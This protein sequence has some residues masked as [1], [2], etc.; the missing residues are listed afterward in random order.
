MQVINV[1]DINSPVKITWKD[2]NYYIPNDGKPHWIP[3]E[4]SDNF[5]G[6]LRIISKD[7]Q[8]PSYQPP[9]TIIDFWKTK[10]ILDIPFVGPPIPI[11][12][13]IKPITISPIISES[14]LISD[15]QIEEK[16]KELE[17]IKY[18]PKDIPVILEDEL[19]ESNTL[20]DDR[21]EVDIKEL[22]RLEVVNEVQEKLAQGKQNK[23]TNVPILNRR[24]TKQYNT[25][26]IK[27]PSIKP[28]KGKRVSKKCKDKTKKEYIERV[29]KNKKYIDR[30]NDNITARLD[31][32]ENLENNN[33][34]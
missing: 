32:I 19:E 22:N 26:A 7:P 31:M 17:S 18:V 9:T 14:N 2:V 4:V 25:G 3:D 6:L 23:Y 27:D 29:N 24:A 16:L 15:E 33:K 12:P 13:T 34:E 8:I 20:E 10:Q 1:W 28:L 5:G 11:Q 21:I 30:A